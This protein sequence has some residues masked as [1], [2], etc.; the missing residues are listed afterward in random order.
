MLNSVVV[1]VL[2]LPNQDLKRLAHVLIVAN[3]F[4]LQIQHKLEQNFGTDI[5]LNQLQS[6]R[7]KK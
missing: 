5:A 7:L 2:L 1:V 4:N 6:L 3:L